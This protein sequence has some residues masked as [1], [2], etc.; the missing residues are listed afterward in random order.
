MK[1][2]AKNAILATKA[3][4]LVAEFAR[5]SAAVLMYHSVQPDPSQYVDS[6]N[7][8]IHSQSSFRLQMEMLARDYQP[9]SLN[10]LSTKLRTGS[11][12]HA[13]SVVITFDDGYSDNYEVAMPILNEL[14]I[15]ATFYA[16]VD[17][18]ENRKLP[19]PSR[20]RWSFRKTRLASWKDAG[21][22]VWTF[23]DPAS[24]EQAYLAACNDC[25]RLSGKM[26]D[27]FV[28][29]FERELDAAVPDSLG[30]LMMSVDQLKGLVRNGHMVGSHTMTHPNMAHVAEEEARNEFSESK[31]RL[32]SMLG[33]P[34]KHFSYPCPAL[35]PHW[36]EQTVE[37]CRALGYE[38]AVTTNSGVTKLGDSLLRLKRIHPTKTAAGLRWN[39]ESAFAGRRI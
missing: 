28:H 14:G 35:S 18:I 3:L 5:P 24:R 22:K 8:I 11:P 2:R 33:L 9:I 26:Q 21:E 7:G 39:L 10:E 17:C 15:P 13:R 4:R 30:S 19:W 27:E 36:S 38:S 16:T 6:L 34:V 1:E 37:Q 31:V 23:S 20:L 29:R 12:L 25:C 32:E